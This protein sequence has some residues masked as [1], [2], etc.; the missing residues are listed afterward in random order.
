M[1]LQS[2]PYFQAHRAVND[3]KKVNVCWKKTYEVLR[4]E[5]IYFLY[6]IIKRRALDRTFII[7]L[8]QK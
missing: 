7:F 4:L 3:F 8:L 5:Y 2:F 6:K 1:N